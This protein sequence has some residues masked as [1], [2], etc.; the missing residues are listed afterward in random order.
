MDKAPIITQDVGVQPEILHATSA[1]E[2]PV[3][4]DSRKK[5]VCIIFFLDLQLFLFSWYYSWLVGCL[6]CCCKLFAKFWYQNSF[7]CMMYLQTY[8]Y[9]ILLGN[10]YHNILLI[11]ENEISKKHGRLIRHVHELSGWLYVGKIFWSIS[12]LQW[13]KISWLFMVTAFLISLYDLS[14]LVWEMK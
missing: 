14:R 5:E 10:N 12:S 1:E 3:K 11:I 7:C 9:I 8:L 6:Y 2:Q 13:T 4:D